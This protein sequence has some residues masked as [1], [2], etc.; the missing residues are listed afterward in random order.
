MKEQ[1]LHLD[2]RA[3]NIVIHVF[4]KFGKVNKAYQLMEE[5]KTK[6]MQ[7]TFVTYGSFIHRLAI[8]DRMKHICYLKKKNKNVLI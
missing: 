6:G 5:M 7:H 8:I 1:G 2:T 4:C 3:Y